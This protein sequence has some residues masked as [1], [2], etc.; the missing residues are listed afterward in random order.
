[1]YSIGVHP[2]AR[3]ARACNAFFVA[4]SRRSPIPPRLSRR[5]IFFVSFLGNL[6]YVTMRYP[7]ITF[8]F[9]F[10]RAQARPNR[11]ARPMRGAPGQ[12]IFAHRSNVARIICVSLSSVIKSPVKGSRSAVS[13]NAACASS[14]VYAIVRAK[15]SAIARES[16]PGK[17]F[18]A[19]SASIPSPSQNAR[20]ASA[21]VQMT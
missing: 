16:A 4:H 20:H 21:R 12:R 17:P 3:S 10:R 18:S 9:F 11:A 14:A 1:M 7:R 8:L 6:S 13:T 15:F 2:N 5:S 19:V